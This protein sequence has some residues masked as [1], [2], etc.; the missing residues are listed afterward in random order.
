MG[1]DLRLRE[2]K[3]KRKMLV[4][5]VFMGRRLLRTSGT[6]TNAFTTEGEAGIFTHT[7]PT[8]FLFKRLFQEHQL[9]TTR[10]ARKYPEQRFLWD[11]GRKLNP[12]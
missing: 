9:A 2:A 10:Q 7:P 5:G 11:H 3:E 6:H 4:P 8:P 12:Q 1:S